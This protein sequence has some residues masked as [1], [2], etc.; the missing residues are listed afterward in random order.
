[1]GHGFEP[2]TVGYDWEMAVVKETG[3][4]LD[5]KEAERLADELRER[6]PWAA[7]GTDLELIESRLGPF[8]SFGELS[9]NTGRFE[10]Y[11]RKALKERGWSL[12]RSGARP[13]EREPIGAHIHVGT[14]RD[15]SAAARVQNGMAA[16]VA[17]FVALTANSPVYRNR[18]GRFKSY[19][20]ASFAEYCSLPQ[21]I[22]SPGATQPTWGIDVCLKLAL[23]STV[24]M[25]VGDGVTSARLM[26]ELVALVAG[27]MHHVAEHDDGLPPSDEAY[28]EMM[29]NRWR[30]A[31]HGLT[32]VFKVGGLDVPAQ[33]V[34]TEALAVAQDGMRRIQA[35]P[36]DL[37]LIREMVRKR[38][39]QAD[40]QL[41]VFD[42]E[43]RDPHRF[44]RSLANIQR[45]ERAFE[46]YLTAAPPL[47]DVTQDDPVAD[48]LSGIE[49]ETPYTLLLR[50]TP[51]APAELDRRLADLVRE[52]R[53]IEGRTRLG[54]RTYTRIDLV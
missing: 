48:L 42:A 38:Q 23:S 35:S 29:L 13:I 40:F 1:M 22:A 26:C 52:G 24:E 54:V 21:T 50:G 49:V 16:Y 51:F 6:V 12:L 46:R 41:A 45:D 43:G 39:T 18:S 15:W 32:A 31:K 36:D 7:T 47:D 14:V 17:P 25:R 37:V 30:A 33:S 4:N 8:R 10:R 19:R 3:E 11:L 2:L 34:L 27:L 28:A 9:E 44:T 53:V 20:V 5:E